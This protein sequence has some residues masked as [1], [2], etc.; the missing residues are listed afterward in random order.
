[1]RLPL[2]LTLIL[3]LVLKLL[4]PLQRLQCNNG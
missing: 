2:A 1:M 4:T 3:S